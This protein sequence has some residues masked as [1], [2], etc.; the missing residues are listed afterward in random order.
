MKIIKDLKL[1]PAKFILIEIQE[2]ILHVC[3][4]ILGEDLE[5]RSY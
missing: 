3:V 1:N 5:R 4:H 2:V